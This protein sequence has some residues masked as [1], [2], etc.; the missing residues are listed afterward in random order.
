M[1]VA[2]LLTQLADRRGV[3]TPEGIR[4]DLNLTREEMGSFAGMTRETITRKLG[5]FK[6]LGYIDYTSNRTIYIQDKQAL[7]DYFLG[8]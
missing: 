3:E 7:K 2:E 6:D 4:I 1:K 5:E 8:C